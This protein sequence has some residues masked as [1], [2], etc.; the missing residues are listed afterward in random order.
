MAARPSGRR[1]CGAPRRLEGRLLRRA[2]WAGRERGV[3]GGGGLRGV[4]T[5]AAAVTS[6]SRAS[7]VSITCRPRAGR[8]PG[9]VR[10]SARARRA[11]AVRVVRRAR[12]GR[13]GPGVSSAA[14]PSVCVGGRGEEGMCVCTRPCVCARARAYKHAC[15]GVRACGRAGVRAC[16]RASARERARYRSGRRWRRGRATSGAC[17]SPAPSCSATVRSP[18]PRSEREEGEGAG[19]GD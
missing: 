8:V 2:E 11:P 5:V 12:P 19:G 15:V 13:G 4:P 10:L 18:P 6:R 17:A 7:R 14:A 16:E 1:R 3:A 9:S